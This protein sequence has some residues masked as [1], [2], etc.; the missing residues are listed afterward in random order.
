MFRRWWWI[1]LVMIPGGLILGLMGG[2]FYGHFAPQKYEA[3]A[4][5]QVTQA[6]PSPGGFHPMST[7]TFFATQFEVITAKKTL[8]MVSSDLGL[9]QRWMLSEQE[10]VER[11]RD[12]ISTNHIKGTDLIEVRVRHTNPNDAAAVANSVVEAYSRRIGTLAGDPGLRVI[13]HEQA[14][15]PRTAVTPN[16][17]LV[18]V[19]AGVAG[20]LLSPL[21]ALLLIAVLH[22]VFPGKRRDANR[23]RTAVIAG[24]IILTI[25]VLGLA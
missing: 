3:R 24:G 17:V 11:L 15:V 8:A 21:M 20:L 18:V 5:V 10:L 23:S 25:C 4:I 13:I 2:V 22:K 1:F 9:A 14:K 19:A 6:V 12:A 7:S 16:V